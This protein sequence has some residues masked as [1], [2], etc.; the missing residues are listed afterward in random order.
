[1]HNT[2]PTMLSS[3]IWQKT[4]VLSC[5]AWWKNNVLFTTL[6]STQLTVLKSYIWHKTSSTKRYYPATFD[7]K[8]QYS[9][10]TLDEKTM[11]YSQDFPVLN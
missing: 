9:H 5:H 1:M 7:K 11:Y 3:Y 4:A 8:Q 2:L 10:A 6:S